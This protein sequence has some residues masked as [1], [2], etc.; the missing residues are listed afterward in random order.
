MKYRIWQHGLEWRWQLFGL[1]A[2]V[3]A[4]GVENSSRAARVAA[5]NRCLSAQETPPEHC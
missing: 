1:D 5:F 4:S 3:L 2:L